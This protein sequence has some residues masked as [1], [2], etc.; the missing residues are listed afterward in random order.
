MEVLVWIGLSQ[1][2]F[3]AII[4]ATKKHA[5]ISDKILSTWLFMLAIAFLISGLEYQIFN[6]HM[7]SNSALIINPAFYLYIKSLTKPNFKLR[8]IQLLHLIPFIIIGAIILFLKVPLSIYSINFSE[9]LIFSL[10]FI[11]VLIISWTAYNG[12]SAIMV[13]N[14]R[15]NLAN[16]FSN[17]EA[18]AKISWLLFVV[19]TYISFCIIIFIF[20]VYTYFTK[21]GFFYLYAASQIFYLVLVYVLGFYGLKQRTI[22]K[23]QSPPTELKYENSVLSDKKKERIKK[24]ILRLFDEQK[25]YL[26]LEFNMNTLSE[27]TGFPKHQIT[28]VLSTEIK[29]NFFQFVNSYRIEAV[30]KQLANKNNPFSIEAIGYECGFNSKSTFYTI[31]KKHTGKTPS[32][33]RKLNNNKSSQPDS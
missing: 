1:S 10:C 19:S 15:K 12:L 22:Y 8:W 18:N 11:L 30:K 24:D 28:E 13:N 25:P 26:D 7:L 23:K 27:L 20:G 16:E 14:H 5:N 6:Q 2:L 33:F 9:D 17:I 32:E 21:S 29:Q 4:I 3:A 31:F